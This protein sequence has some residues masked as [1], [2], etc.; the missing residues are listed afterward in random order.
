M[1]KYLG[2][3]VHAFI[4]RQQ[5]SGIFSDY[6]DIIYY[7]ISLNARFIAGIHIYSEPTFQWHE[8]VAFIK[9]KLQTFRR[10]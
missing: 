1:I 3:S 4:Y 7:V 8:E 6:H 9:R 10:K 5:V 2:W